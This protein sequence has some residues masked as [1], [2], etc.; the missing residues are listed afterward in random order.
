MKTGI[1]KKLTAL[2]AVFA[3]ALCAFADG[4]VTS[5]SVE[6]TTGT[7]AANG[8][9]WT[10]SALTY[11]APT[12]ND[13]LNRSET[14]WYAGI[15]RT[16]ALSY[17]GTIL[18]RQYTGT[19]ASGITASFS[20][21]A[22]RTIEEYSVVNALNLLNPDASPDGGGIKNA[23]QTGGL[24][25]YMNTVDWNVW[26]TP[27]IMKA[28]SEKGE[29]YIAT[30]TI[31]DETYTITIPRTLELVDD[32]GVQCWPEPEFDEPVS[33]ED[34]AITLSATEIIVRGETIGVE[35]SQVTVNKV[36]LT[37]GSDYVVDETS[38]FQATDVGEYTVTIN[39]IGNYKG[40]ASTTWKIIEP[41]GEFAADA[42]S[43]KKGDPAYGSIAAETPRRLD[44]TDTTKLVYK[45]DELG[46][47]WEAAVVISWPHEVTSRSILQAATSVRYTDADHATVAY[48]DEEVA[49]PRQI[50]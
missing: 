14:G 19:A 5:D 38:V 11:I 47:R 46:E 4:V 2:V 26:V 9:N 34:A 30:L 23:F 50:G 42:M 31:A 29:D 36:L 3:G 28:V 16:W 40:S 24:T 32:K 27:E 35:L 45:N 25:R 17:T 18:N 12:S 44:I 22:G 15:K 13:S 33:I 21:N 41:T 10:A 20:D 48:S 1:V 7:L 49:A 6:A 39:G 37:E 43:V 8:N